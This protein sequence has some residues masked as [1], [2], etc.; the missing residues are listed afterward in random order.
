MNQAAITINL[1]F[2][3]VTSFISVNPTVQE[4]NPKAGLAQAAMVAVEPGQHRS[5]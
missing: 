1:I 4:Y 2:W 3:L 5:S